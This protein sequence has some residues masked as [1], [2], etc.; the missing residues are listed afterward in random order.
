M[1]ENKEIPKVNK[2]YE[3]NGY[4]VEEVDG[5][6]E[7]VILHRLDGSAER[8]KVLKSSL[9]KRYEDKYSIKFVSGSTSYSIS[10][11]NVVTET[12]FVPFS[13]LVRQEHLSQLLG[14][15]VVGKIYAEVER[16]I[17][18]EYREP[19]VLIISPKWSIA[20]NQ[21]FSQMMSMGNV[22]AS[23][24][25]IHKLNT[26]YCELEVYRSHDVETFKIF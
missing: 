16:I 5:V 14:S 3:I 23:D 19:K 25:R 21:Y 1:E 22:L 12:P 6:V 10:V 9:V 15:D 24:A 18:H 7:Y 2:Q 17:S 11:Y 8:L 13:E 20:V 4:T 26:P